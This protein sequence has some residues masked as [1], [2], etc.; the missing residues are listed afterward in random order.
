[1]NCNCGGNTEGIHKVTRDKT[2]QGEYQECP[3]CG[4]IKWLWATDKL[5]DEVGKI[6]PSYNRNRVG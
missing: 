4:R 3:N 2:L 6:E 5:Q 1:M